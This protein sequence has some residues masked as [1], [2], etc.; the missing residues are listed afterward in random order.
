MGATLCGAAIARTTTTKYRAHWIQ[1]RDFSKFMCWSPWLNMAG[2]SSSQKLAYFAIYLWR[3]GWNSTGR[4]NQYPTIQSKL[5]SVF[6]YHR[7]YVDVD[8]S[9]SPLLRI[10]LQGIKRLSDPTKKK[11][12]VTPAFLRILR[13]SLHL[14]RPRERLLWGSVLLGYFFLLRRSEYLLVGGHR[15]FYCLKTKNVFFSDTR[16]SPVSAA[17]AT[18]VTIGLS[19]AKISIW[20]RTM[21]QSGHRSLCPVRALKH[22]LQ[23]RK[24]LRVTDH[25]NLCADLTAEAVSKA[26]KDTARRAGVDSSNYSTHS[27][28]SGGATALLSG[29]A[30]SLSIKILGRWISRCFEE[31]PLQSAISRDA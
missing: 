3:Y 10:L 25:G 20:A 24:H 30:D 23:A 26:L 15:Y 18:A 21:H 8:L 2:R 22:V 5:S 11:M 28:R 7:R 1:W 9:R 12:P 6:W 31:Y 16:G 13:R 14:S 4:G 29:K 17:M 27:L 19:G